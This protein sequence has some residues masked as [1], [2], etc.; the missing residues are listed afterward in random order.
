MGR[1]GQLKKLLPNLK[2]NYGIWSRGRFGA[3]R[4]EVANQDHSFMQG[5]EAVDG[6]LFGAPEMTKWDVVP[7]EACVAFDQSACEIWHEE[8][9]SDG[10]HSEEYTQDDTTCLA[11]T[12]FF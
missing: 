12:K 8:D 9:I 2:D 10:E 4:Y 11:G 6:I 5:V 3:Y 7:S 1:E